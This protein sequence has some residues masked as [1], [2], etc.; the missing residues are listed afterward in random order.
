MQSLSGR[1]DV[2]G[3][4]SFNK[5]NLMSTLHL[6]RYTAALTQHVV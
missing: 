4:M 2:G 1:V 6:H 3:Q 5:V